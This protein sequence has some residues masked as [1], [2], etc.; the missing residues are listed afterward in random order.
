MW[1]ALVILAG[2]LFSSAQALL[3]ESVRAELI[4]SQEEK[5]LTLAG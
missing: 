5:G 1:L 3:Q 2:A 4:R